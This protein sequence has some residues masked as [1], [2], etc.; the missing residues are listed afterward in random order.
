MAAHTKF[1]DLCSQAAATWIV[2]LLT[3]RCCVYIVRLWD[4]L[5]PGL[6]DCRIDNEID[7][8]KNGPTRQ[9]CPGYIKVRVNPN[10]AETDKAR[11]TPRFPPPVGI[12][13][14][15]YSFWGSHFWAGISDGMLGTSRGMLST[16]RIERKVPPIS[17]TPGNYGWALFSLGISLLGWHLRWDAGHLPDRA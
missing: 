15:Q 12:M 3:A 14:G 10:N 16:S 2:G 5:L 4:C 9:Q 8:N 1:L 11:S 17:T 6:W 7:Q 13:A